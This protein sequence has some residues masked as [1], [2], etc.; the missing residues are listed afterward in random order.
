MTAEKIHSSPQR[1]P[2]VLSLS[3]SVFCFALFAS[4]AEATQAALDEV[5]VLK[6]HA[7][8]T[9]DKMTEHTCRSKNKTDY[10]DCCIVLGKLTAKHFQD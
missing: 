1:V 4:L 3:L 5:Q 6:F 10:S 8:S 9:I 7:V 2:D